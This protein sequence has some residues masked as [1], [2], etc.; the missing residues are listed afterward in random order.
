MKAIV[1][2]TNHSSSERLRNEIIRFDSKLSHIKSFTKNDIIRDHFSFSQVQYIF[3]SWNMPI[4]TSKEIK[5]FFPNLQ[6]VFYA[7]GDTSYFD[8]PFKENMIKIFDISDL[9][10]AVLL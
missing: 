9:I 3:S 2:T 4:F 7:A 1:L 8:K 6:F 5:L 10:F